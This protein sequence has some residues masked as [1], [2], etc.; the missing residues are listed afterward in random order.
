MSTTNGLPSEILEALA[1]S[2]LTGGQRRIIDT[3]WLLQDKTIGSL[4]VALFTGLTQRHVILNL[5]RL[6]KYKVIQRRYEENKKIGRGV[7]P[8]TVINMNF[9]EWEVPYNPRI[10]VHVEGSLS[11]DKGTQRDQPL[12]E[13]VHVEGSLSVDNNNLPKQ[14]VEPSK[15]EEKEKKLTFGV[16]KNVLLTPEEYDKLEEKF[17]HAETLLKI[18]KLSTY[19][20]SRN[21]KYKSHY[22]TILNW[23]FRENENVNKGGNY[24]TYRPKNQGLSGQK[25]AGAFSDVEENT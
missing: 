25:S 13:K 10:K 3:V 8:S 2:N 21:K 23:S 9:K 4:D 22:L 18:D 24:G 17:G 11:D 14:P 16:G 12:P 6:E 15:K 19:M 7:K 5:N 20:G 1:K